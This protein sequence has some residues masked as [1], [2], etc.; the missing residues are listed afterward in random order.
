MKTMNFILCYAV[1]PTNYE[2]L[3][4]PLTYTVIKF[5]MQLEELKLRYVTVV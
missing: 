2:K 4:T 3:K 5:D 1:T